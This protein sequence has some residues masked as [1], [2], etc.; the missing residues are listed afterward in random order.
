MNAAEK[1]HFYSRLAIATAV[2]AI[3]LFHFWVNTFYFPRHTIPDEEEFGFL[4]SSMNMAQ[5]LQTEP[6]ARLRLIFSS[7]DAVNNNNL[8]NLLGALLYLVHP[9]LA[10]LMLTSTLYLMLTLLFFYLIGRELG[11]PWGGL[12]ALAFVSFYPVVYVWSRLYY[13]DIAVMMTGAI[14]CY[15][16]LK[17]ECFTHLP[18]AAAFG[19]WAAVAPRFGWTVSDAAA[20]LMVVLSPA[21]PAAAA[22]VIVHRGGERRRALLGVGLALVGFLVLFNYRWAFAA[23]D[24]L[25]YEGVDLARSKYLGGNVLVHPESLF[26]YLPVLFR[27]LAGPA[28]TLAF[29]LTL[30]L[31]FRK[32]SW[33][34]LYPFF[35]LLLPLV[36]LSLVPKKNI[37]YVHALA[38]A[39]GLMTAV[40]LSSPGAKRRL[41]LIGALVAVALLAVGAWQYAR[42]TFRPDESR[43]QYDFDRLRDVQSFFEIRFPLHFIKRCQQTELRQMEKEVREWAAQRPAGADPVRVFISST[44]GPRFGRLVQIYLRSALAGHE[45]EIVDVHDL[46]LQYKDTELPDTV[47]RYGTEYLLQQRPFE[48]YQRDHYDLTILIHDQHSPDCQDRVCEHLNV[49]AGH[50]Y[51]VPPA[52]WD[53]ALVPAVQRHLAAGLADLSA[54]FDNAPGER[55]D[56]QV[57][58][59]EGRITMTLVDNPQGI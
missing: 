1:H 32:P 48:K 36:V 38:P 31:Y 40:A 3:M 51:E 15:L 21:L 55:R 47:N 59:Q 5:H 39:M 23:I 22:G 7:P 41:R 33:K 52:A 20:A 11:G 58:N 10:A 12:S 56:Y 19:I 27:I 8:H 57:C 18:Y 42:I 30:P 43:R 28:W 16:L 35:W 50:W 53:P 44:G 4:L 17:T 37:N 2:G 6:L 29:L 25:R 26:A 14:G 54:S 34:K 24:Y 9:S 49:I 46:Y 45:Y 13:C